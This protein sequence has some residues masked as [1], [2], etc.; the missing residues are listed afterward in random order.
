MRR[1][2]FPRCG[3][4]RRGRPFGWSDAV[5]SGDVAQADVE[6]TAEGVW[7]GALAPSF[8]PPVGQ[9]VVRWGRQWRVHE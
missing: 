8:P 2:D 1:V 4:W 9:K 5:E 3:D 6:P 7:V